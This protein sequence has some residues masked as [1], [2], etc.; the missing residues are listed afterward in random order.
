MFSW[1]GSTRV[2]M[3]AS[4]FPTSSHD[5]GI[6]LCLGEDS[7]LQRRISRIKNMIT[8]RYGWGWR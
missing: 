2:A 8:H 3:S 1:R 4:R 6:D 5:V 7:A